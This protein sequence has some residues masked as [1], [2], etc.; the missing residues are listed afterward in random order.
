[1]T[2][3]AVLG[4]GIMGS[5]MARTLLRDG[6]DVRVWNR[7][8]ARAAPLAAS[9]ATLAGDVPEAVRGADA[10]LTMVPTGEVVASLADALLPELAEDAV[11][12]QTSTVGGPWTD[13]LLDR[14][15]RAG[16]MMLDSPVSGSSGP[17]EQGTLTMIVSGEVPAL[18]R[19]RPVL[20]ALGSRTVHVGTGGEA[21]RIKLIVNGWMTA[22]VLAMADALDA[23]GRLGVDPAHVM[24][25]VDGGPL[26][27]PYAL[28]K[29]R[30][31]L[32]GDFAPGFPVDLARK[33]LRLLIDELPDASPL[34]RTVEGALGAASDAGRGRADVAAVR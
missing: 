2:T 31:I 30:E 6:H 32:R 3:V 33:D 9:G 1:M 11:W 13:R 28:D 8:A 5:A 23:C 22:T 29:A 18:E 24:D 15:R 10:V 34:Y 25:V 16:R 7:T 27:M 20:D 14:A 26:A 17:A 19:A 12:V 4:T 21:S